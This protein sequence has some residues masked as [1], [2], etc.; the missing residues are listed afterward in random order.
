L[1][2]G[3]RGAGATVDRTDGTELP[4]PAREPFPLH[5]PRQ[6]ALAAHLAEN[7]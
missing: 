2:I 6:V 1:P 5:R 4:L 7:A 3:F